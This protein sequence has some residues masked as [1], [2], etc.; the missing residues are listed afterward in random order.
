MPSAP[1]TYDV[2]L[3][4]MG[5][6]GSA[7][8]WQ[9]ARRGVRVLGLEQFDIP[10]SRG[11][12]HGFSR[13]IRLAY[14]EHADYVPLL[15]RAYEN[16]H[17]LESVSGQ[18]L[19][20][21]TGGVYAGPPGSDRLARTSTAAES[22]GIPY[23]RLSPAELTHRYAPF[24]LPDDYE[25]LFEPSAGFLL[26]EKAIAA[27]V[28]SALNAGAEIHAHEPV[29]SWQPLG[30]SGAGEGV[31]VTTSR[32]TYEA[33]RVVFC[34]GAWTVRLVQDLGVP[35]RVTRQTLGWTWPR[36][37]R[38][39]ELGKFPVWSIAREDGT[40][41]YGFPMMPDNPGFK[42]A[43]HHRND[44][45]TVDTVIRDPLPGDE[46]DIRYPISR[47]LPAAE[48]PLLGLR[49]CLYTNTPDAHFIVDTHPQDSRVV[50][51]CGFSGHGFKF[52]SVMGEVLADLATEGK[53]AHPIGFLGL[54]RFE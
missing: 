28:I 32:G 24:H 38:L 34:G 5:A 7:A 9:L 42:T 40:S 46:A 35:L 41:H 20:H 16:W 36:E 14:H 54:K 30:T 25:I 23:E 49:V 10:H 39:F 29:V 50:I 15:R 2:I 52:A 27:Q 33:G 44:E 53:T 37:P 6:M 48:G 31:S 47:F 3:I 11:S 43:H 13:M 21:I 4:G 1:S 51:A 22:H 26:P 45:T 19:L 8:C 17:E 12:S 18:K